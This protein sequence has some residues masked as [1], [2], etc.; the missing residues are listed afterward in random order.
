MTEI[1]WASRPRAER[2]AEVFRLREAKM[3]FRDIAEAMGMNEKTL[4][5]YYSDPDGAK[6]AARRES[7]RGRCRQC[8][9]PTDGSRGQGK[10]PELCTFCLQPRWEPARILAAMRDFYAEHGRSP[11]EVDG[12]HNSALPNE[13]PVRRRFGTWNAAL[14]A[15]GLP[16]NMDR[17]PETQAAIEAELA[18]G[19]SLEEVAARRG[20]GAA[21]VQMRM[22]YRGRTV[23]ELRPPGF[24]GR[25]R[26]TLPWSDEETARFVEAWNRG[27]TAA[28]LAAA[29]SLSPE[30]ISS[31]AHSLRRRGYPVPYRRVLRRK[32]AA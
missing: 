30:S 27:D 2:V 23:T 15:A 20:W 4:R 19:D 12:H 18:R 26:P 10:A 8:G 13:S 25:R 9:R 24:G 5:N 21:N 29:F 17:S 22:Y 28:E 32:A 31:R 14:R 11:R 16:V 3:T 6:Q 1:D 7:Y